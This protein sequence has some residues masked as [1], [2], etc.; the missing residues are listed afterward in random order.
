MESPPA[1]LS[2]ASA[3]ELVI[4]AVSAAVAVTTRQITQITTDYI[5]TPSLT[6]VSFLGT[7]TALPP[8]VLTV[9]RLELEYAL[10]RLG[11]SSRSR[12]AASSVHK[13]TKCLSR[14]PGALEEIA[15]A[16]FLG[17]DGTTD[18]VDIGNQHFSE[19]CSRRSCILRTSTFII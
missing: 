10:D 5:C 3:A 19:L 6:V 14:N 11:K 17:V 18:F 8:C 7:T 4:S 9:A 1:G 12:E 2:A 13:E 16:Q 15:R